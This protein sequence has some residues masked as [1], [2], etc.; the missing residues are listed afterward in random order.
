MLWKPNGRGNLRPHIMSR[1]I[2]V[3]V[4][5]LDHLEELE[6]VQL[7]AFNNRIHIERELSRIHENCQILHENF[8]VYAP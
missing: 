6:E 7:A 8:R 4:E 3:A 1:D 5:F 2:T